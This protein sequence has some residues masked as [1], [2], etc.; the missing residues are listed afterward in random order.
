M[1]LDNKWNLPYADYNYA[2]WEKKIAKKEADPDKLRME[3]LNE[4]QDLALRSLMQNYEAHQN[5][6]KERDNEFGYAIEKSHKSFV[7]SRDRLNSYLDQVAKLKRDGF[8][9][10]QL[11]S[12]QQ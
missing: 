10:D 7:K 5:F 3:L 8:F 1:E 12:P 2:A 11:Q 6:F 9:A 4:I